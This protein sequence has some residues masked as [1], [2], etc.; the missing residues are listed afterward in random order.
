MYIEQQNLDKRFESPLNRRGGRRNF[1]RN[2]STS[3]SNRLSRG[4][5]RGGFVANPDTRR[6]Q[7][8]SRLSLQGKPNKPIYSRLTRNKPPLRSN[9]AVQRGI[10]TKSLKTRNAEEFHPVRINNG[11]I[12]KG[13]RSD[14]LL[15]Q[16]ISQAK[17]KHLQDKIEKV[18]ALQAKR[19]KIV[20]R[21]ER[22]SW[23]S[24]SKVLMDIDHGLTVSFP[25]EDIRKKPRM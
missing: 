19:A 13:L 11:A 3:L 23:R 18:R 5:G 4:V 7:N 6:N 12:V 17:S 8:F 1:S 10:S 16:K 21:K 25:N 20:E 22:N 2:L 15:L 14:Q 24:P 9:N